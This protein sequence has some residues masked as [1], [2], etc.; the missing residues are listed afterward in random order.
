M[1]IFK[2]TCGWKL[3]TNNLVLMTQYSLKLPATL[4]MKKHPSL[5][6]WNI[7]VMQIVSTSCDNEDD[8]VTKLYID[9]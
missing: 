9:Y 6:I 3:L 2:P 5:R 7:L 4:H 8:V 1:K